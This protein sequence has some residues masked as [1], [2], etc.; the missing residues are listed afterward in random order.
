MNP[1]LITG[2]THRFAPTRG[3]RCLRIAVS[4]L[5]AMLF[6]VT[7]H[8]QTAKLIP[9]W[10]ASDEKN[11]A[12]I[13]HTAWQ[14]ILN[15]YLRRARLGRQSLR[16]RGA[17]GECRRHCQAGVILGVFAVA[18]PEESIP[19]PNRRRTGSISTTP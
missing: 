18:G 9:E 11:V 10:A 2:R 16:L 5:V 7:A 13:E 4:L 19:G 15:D 1:V 14:E 17:Q 12:H 8:A 3:R 6:V